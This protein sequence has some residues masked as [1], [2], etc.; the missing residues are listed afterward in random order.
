MSLA[1]ILNTASAAISNSDFKIAVV[2]GNVANADDTSYS[3]KTVQSAAITPDLALTQSDTTRV[4]DAYLT[5]L[6][7]SSGSAAG[8]DQAI[9]AALSQYDAALGSVNAGDDLASRLS[10]FQTALSSLSANAVDPSSKANVVSAASTL[11]SSIRSLSGSVQD[12]RSQA[13]SD[14]ATTVSEINTATAK[15]DALNRQIVAGGASGA[16]VTDLQDQRD[17]ALQT[18]SGDMGVSYYV[19]PD[20]RMQVFS[21]SGDLLVGDQANALSYSASSTLSASAT[22][23]GA[24]GGIMLGGKDVTA[25]ITSGKLG[26]LIT[27]RD[28]TFVQEQAKLD[29]FASTLIGA[30]N[31]ASNAGSAYPAPSSLT[32]STTVSAG[33][34][35]SGTG[36]LRVALTD[37]TGAVVST[38]DIDLSTC[39][40]VG[41]LVNALNGVPGLSAQIDSQGRMT[42]SATNAGQGVALADLGAAVAPSGV[43]VSAYFGLNNLFSG[44]DATDI[45]VSSAI[46]AT[47]GNLPTGALNAAAGLAVGD[48]AV[49]S[50]DTSVADKLSSALS[51]PQGFAAAGGFAA[52]SV[53]PQTYAAA[54]VS[55]AATLVSD[56]SARADSS[57]ATF[58]A[59]Q[60][61]L[62]NLTNVN[63][64]EELAQLTSL[65]QQYQANA[66]M[67]TAERA[68]FQALMTMMA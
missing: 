58:S 62:Q 61:Q 37:P 60:S 29:A 2:N 19:T 63:T 9:S 35:F 6:V 45:A 1:G 34:P 33:L 14:I 16:D 17:A 50:A 23:P 56:A 21:A 57:Q 3:R 11:A 30:A 7:A 48:I 26:G 46:A 44:A 27:L 65:Q 43:G 42:L 47:P 40:T 32:G 41:D 31:A 49:A 53:S 54:I 64:D 12:L 67:I 8:S 25:S 5:R 24:I 52:Q 22:Y 59:A 13:N 51:S 36:T 66:Q 39:A 18:L 55:S 20:N 28:Q 10:A 15:I 38:Q 4:A 68:L